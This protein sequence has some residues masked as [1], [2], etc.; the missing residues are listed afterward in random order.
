M[1]MSLMI[2][3]GNA[4]ATR[5]IASAPRRAVTTSYP[6]ARSVSDT[7]SKRLGSSS[8]T[9]NCL[10]IATLL[11]AGTCACAVMPDGQVQSECTPTTDLTLD[12]DLTS[13][14]RHYVLAKIQT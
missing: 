8:T 1:R 13:H 5:T 10:A 14:L 6:S 12:A 4:S 11:A 3:S 9:S 7:A 2:R